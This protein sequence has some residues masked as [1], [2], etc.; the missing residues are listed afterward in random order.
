[1]AEVELVEGTSDRPFKVLGGVVAK[2]QLSFAM[3]DWSNARDMVDQR[4]REEAAKLGADAVVH[5]EYRRTG[6]RPASWGALSADGRAVAFDTPLVR[7]TASGD[8]R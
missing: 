5:V 7:S 4:L 2:V 3:F 8:R 1:V 6:M